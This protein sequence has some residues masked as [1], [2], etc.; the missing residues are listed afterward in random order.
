[1]KILHVTAELAKASGVTVFCG[2]V[3]NEL[4]KAGNEVAIFVPNRIPDEYILHKDVQV[5]THFPNINEWK[6]EVVHIHGIWSLFFIRA[7]IWAKRNKLPV[8]WSPHGSL[9]PWALNYKR[10]KKRVALVAYQ[11]LCLR[12][13]NLI[14]VTGE[15]ETPDIRRL[16]LSNP[17]V[18]IP[19][20]VHISDEGIEKNTNATRIALFISRVHPIKGLFNLVDAWAQLRPEGWILQLAGP[21]Q[22]GHIEEVLQRASER[23]IADSVQYLGEVY[24]SEKNKKYAEADLFVLP[25]FSENF[26]SVVLESLAQGTPVITTKGTPWN[27]LQTRH[28]G[29]WIDIGVEPLV[30][31]LRDAIERS[32]SERQAMGQN[33]IQL[34]LDKYTWS[35]IGK[36]MAEAY[37]NLLKDCD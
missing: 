6:P 2:E 15:F 7:F 32:D 26:G 14:H 11:W 18:E 17:V 3:A 36:Q 5:I 4:A 34:V 13:A 16:K 24:D 35:S 10:L 29:W 19:L 37:K 9:T 23:G 31:A 33:G 30:V 20:G 21:S 22:D 8:V 28:C 27:E 25:S 1:M 12:L